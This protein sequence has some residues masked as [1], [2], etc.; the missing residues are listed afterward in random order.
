MNLISAVY[1]CRKCF[2]YFTNFDDLTMHNLEHPQQEN[3][4]LCCYCGE[5][6]QS[7]R[8]L[9][10]HINKCHFEEHQLECGYCS[11]NC[12]TESDMGNHLMVNHCSN[13]K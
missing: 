6:S 12:L 8:L 13:G 2:K 9:M 10:H 4:N 11:F 7:M 1:P 3:M 5:Y